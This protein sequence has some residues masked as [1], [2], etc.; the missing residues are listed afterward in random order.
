M[1]HRFLPDDG[2]VAGLLALMLLTDAGLELL[3]SLDS[4]P[5]IARRHRL[6][7]VRAHLQELAGDCVAARENYRLAARRTTSLPEQR[8]LRDRA[9]KQ[10]QDHDVLM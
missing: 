9:D 8:Y 6:Y 1:V 3:Q 4:D 5:R 2:E 10:V 7:A